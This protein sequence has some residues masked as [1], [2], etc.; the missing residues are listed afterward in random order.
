MMQR[1]TVWPRHIQEFFFFLNLAWLA[2]WSQATSSKSIFFWRH[3]LPFVHYLYLHSGVFEPEWVVD[4]IV[5]SL[6]LAVLLFGLMQFLRRPWRV[7]PVLQIPAGVIAV[8]GFPLLALYKPILF[9]R[10]PRLT[11]AGLTWPLFFEIA[12][13]VA[14]ACFYYLRKWPLPSAA[15]VLLLVMHFGLWTWLTG[16]DVSLIF[17]ARQYG[18]TGIAFWASSLFYWGC[19]VFGFLASLAWGLYVRLVVQRAPVN[20]GPTPAPVA[21]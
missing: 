12:A 1:S 19:P 21:S 20:S 18:S 17:N 4:Q 6:C 5:W 8:A 16:T 7:S 13:A 10:N 2:I 9:F 3:D 14:C 11:N 15:S